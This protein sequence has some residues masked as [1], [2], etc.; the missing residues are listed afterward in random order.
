MA[1]NH[2][3]PRNRVVPLAVSP[4]T[5]GLVRKLKGLCPEARNVDAVLGPLLEA[6]IANKKPRK[7]V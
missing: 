6:A 7:K 2:N 4:A 5:R 1:K 3:L